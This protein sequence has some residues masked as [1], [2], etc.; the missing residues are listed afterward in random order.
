MRTLPL[1][2]LA[3]LGVGACDHPSDAGNPAGVTNESIS[4]GNENVQSTRDTTPCPFRNSSGWQ[5]Y[6]ENG[7]LNVG[8]RLDIMMA[9][10]KP[11]LRKRA[12]AA[13]GVVAFD[14]SLDPSPGT[15]ISERVDYKGPGVPGATRGEIYCGGERIQEFKLYL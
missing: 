6:M 1:L 5:G 2:V 4:A 11:T 15:A 3:S 10:F 7:Q 9:G 14:L 12:S 8:G 13:P